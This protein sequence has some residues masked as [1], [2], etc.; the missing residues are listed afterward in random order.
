MSSELSRKFSATGKSVKPIISSRFQIRADERSGKPR[1]TVSIEFAHTS[2][3]V[4]GNGEADVT[5]TSLA[6][7]AVTPTS[8]IFPAKAL[9]GTLPAST[10]AIG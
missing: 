7:V 8:T 10:S 4:I 1:R 2:T 3:P 5:N 9:A 6:I